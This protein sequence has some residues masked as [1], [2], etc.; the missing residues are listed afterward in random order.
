MVLLCVSKEAEL[1]QNYCKHTRVQNNDKS[2]SESKI[3]FFD[4]I[5]K[6]LG[7]LTPIKYKQP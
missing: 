3:M 2:K 6:I 1:S 7:G 4:C 5:L